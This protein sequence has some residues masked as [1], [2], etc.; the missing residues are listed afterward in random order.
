MRALDAETERR[1]LQRTLGTL[2][3]IPAA[4][5][6][7]GVLFG[8]RTLPGGENQVTATLDGEYRFT[9]VFWLATAPLI[10]SRLPRLE[11]DTTTL[12]L[13]M[14]TVFAGG[15]AR[16]LAWRHSGRPHAM[17]IPAIG[18]ELVGMPAMAM[19][20]RRVMRRAAAS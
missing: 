7:A 13:L 16:M 12:P 5:G 3:S 19:W 14:A 2:A 10:W 8:P 20:H 6:L 17:F 11:E 9:A 4:S 1:L 18:L 15:I